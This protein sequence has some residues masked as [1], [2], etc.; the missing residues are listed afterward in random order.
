[1]RTLWSLFVFGLL[2]LIDWIFG[3]QDARRRYI[4]EHRD[5]LEQCNKRN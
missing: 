2:S 3:L 5:E 1:M 4:E